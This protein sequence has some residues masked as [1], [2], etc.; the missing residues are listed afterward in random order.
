VSGLFSGKDVKGNGYGLIL[1]TFPEFS[2]GDLRKIKDIED[3]VSV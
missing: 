3:S 1:G 2:W